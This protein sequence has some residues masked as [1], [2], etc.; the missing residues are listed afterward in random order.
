MVSCASSSDCP[1]VLGLAYW[2]AS[3]VA[4]QKVV[5]QVAVWASRT[6]LG[7]SLLLSWLLSSLEVLSSLLSSDE[8]ERSVDRSVD[9]ELLDRLGDVVVRLD[10]S[11]EEEEEEEVTKPVEFSW[12]VPPVVEP[13]PASTSPAASTAATV[14]PRTVPHVLDRMV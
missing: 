9:D 1:P 11:L 2:P 4:W 3:R 14:R 7:S 5:N 6:P 10:S 8:V 13:Q 12:A